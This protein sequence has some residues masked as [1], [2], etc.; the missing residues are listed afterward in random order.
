MQPVPVAR[1]PHRS[2][3]HDAG[4]GGGRRRGCVTPAGRRGKLMDTR[5]KILNPEAA[6]RACTV[7]TGT[8]DVVLA[9][10]ARELA[11]IR[12]THPG[13]PLLAVVLPLAGTLLPRRGRGAMGGAPPRGGHARGR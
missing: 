10:D 7:V 1:V 9:E 12:A 2:P 3:V 4:D 6:P 5:N 13:R 8:F 11:Q